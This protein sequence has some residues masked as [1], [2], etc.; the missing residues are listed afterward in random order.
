MN[1]KDIV[2]VVIV[3]EILVSNGLFVSLATAQED[4]NVLPVLLGTWLL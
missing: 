3:I 2:T 1:K 4:E